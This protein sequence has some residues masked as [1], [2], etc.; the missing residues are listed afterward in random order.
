MWRRRGT[1]WT[2][3]TAVLA[4]ALTGC[5]G[6]GDSGGG[7]TVSAYVCEP[8]S[9]IPM[10]TNEQCGSQVLQALFTP[11]VRY[12]ADTSVPE[13]TGMAESITSADQRVWTIKLRP[14]FTF[15]NGEAVDAQSY[16]RAWNA[17]AYGPNAY[18]DSY[19]YENIA[20][21]DDLQGAKPKAKEMSGLKAV[22][23]TTLQV[24]LKEPFSQYPVTLGYNA[25]YPVPASFTSDPKAYE[26]APIGNGPFQMDGVWEHNQQI[27]TTRYPRYAGGKKPSID[28]VTFRIYSNI[29]TAYNDLL[30]GS[31]D[32][33]DSLPP[34]RLSEARSTFGDRFIDRPS[35]AFTYIGFPLYDRRFRSADLRTAFSMAID[36]QAII[37]A[38]YNGAYTPAR[39]LV[40]PV[41]AGARPDPCGS[42]CT[43][44]PVKAKQLFD[45]AGGYSGT[46]TLWFNSGQ[47]H[48]KWME[49]V[50]NQLRTNLGIADIRF[51][52]LDFAQYNPKLDANQMTGPFRLAW[53]MDYPSPQNYLQPIYSTTGSSNYSRYTNPRVDQLLAQGNAAGSVAAGITYYQRAEDLILADLPTIPM[54]FQKVQGAHSARTD[55]VVVDAFRRIR[56]DDITLR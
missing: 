45:R 51:K 17:G 47:G 48:E 18:N 13:Y 14:G 37:K 20:G 38:V 56:F 30:G 46:L 39:S 15:H 12:N 34:E 23:A 1:R 16:L 50:A 21:Y 53:L 43:Y 6:S 22:D 27:K 19:F 40:S 4:L 11:L 36:R 41:V 9:L 24:T 55:H 54:W 2:A 44:Q 26:K 7:N 52:S 8:A 31:L 28:G 29:N 33:M 10:N 3:A 35:S 5:G 49:A 42:A 25:F 32:I